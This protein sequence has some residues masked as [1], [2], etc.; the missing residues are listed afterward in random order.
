MNPDGTVNQGG[1]PV[2]IDQ[3]RFEVN[4]LLQLPFHYANVNDA[5]QMTSGGPLPD[6]AQF[7]EFQPNA[8]NQ[9]GGGLRAAWNRL[10]STTSLAITTGSVNYP[11]PI[12]SP[13]VNVTWPTI[14]GMRIATEGSVGVGAF[15]FVEQTDRFQPGV[16]NFQNPDAL[17]STDFAIMIPQPV[18]GVGSDFFTLLGRPPEIMD[19]TTYWMNLTAVTI[20]DGIVVGTYLVTSR[21]AM[22][23]S[24]EV[25]QFHNI[26]PILID[27]GI[28]GAQFRFDGTGGGTSSA[29]GWEFQLNAL[30]TAPGAALV[31]TDLANDVVFDVY[32]LN[33]AT[34]QVDFA[35]LPTV[36]GRTINDFNNL[37][38]VQFEGDDNSFERPVFN[39]QTLV[40]GS[41]STL[42]G[43]E[44]RDN[45]AVGDNRILRFEL[46]TDTNFTRAEIET[47]FAAGNNF[48]IAAEGNVGLNID[49]TGTVRGTTFLPGGSLLASRVRVE[50]LVDDV[51]A[52]I[53]AII[54]YTDTD[55]NGWGQADISGNGIYEFGIGDTRAVYERFTRDLFDTLQLQVTRVINH[56]YAW[57]D[58][59]ADVLQVTDAREFRNQ[60]Q[61]QPTPQLLS[62]STQFPTAGPSVSGEDRGNQIPT[63]RGLDNFLWNTNDRS[64]VET[65]EGAPPVNATTPTLNDFVG[66]FFLNQTT[67][68]MYYWKPT[69]QAVANNEPRS[70]GNYLRIAG[71]TSV[72]TLPDNNP[73][74]TAPGVDDGSGNVDESNIR[75]S[76][77]RSAVY[78]FVGPD[79]DGWEN[80]HNSGNIFGTPVSGDI[81]QFRD[82]GTIQ[83]VPFEDLLAG[84][85]VLVES[86]IPTDP[87]RLVANQ[88]YGFR[89]STRDRQIPAGGPRIT[90]DNFRLSLRTGSITTALDVPA[91]VFDSGNSDTITSNTT[92]LYRVSWSADDIARI[93]A[94]TPATGEVLQARLFVPN[95]VENTPDLFD[96]V[97]SHNPD[98]DTSQ[99]V[100]SGEAVVGELPVWTSVDGDVRGLRSESFQVLS[101]VNGLLLESDVPFDAA[102]L[103]AN[104]R[105]SFRVSTAFYPTNP[106]PT[107]RAQDFQISTAGLVHGA[108]ILDHEDANDEG[109]ATAGQSVFL[110]TTP[111]NT[112]AANPDFSSLVFTLNGNILNR[113]T[114]TGTYTAEVVPNPNGDGT[115]VWQITLNRFIAQDQSPYSIQFD[116]TTQDVIQ[117]F[118]S[119]VYRVSWSQAD[120]DALQASAANFPDDVLRV[121]IN[122]PNVG[123]TLVLHN[124][125]VSGSEITGSGTTGQLVRWAGPTTLEATTDIGTATATTPTDVDD[126]STRVAT[127]EFVHNAVDLLPVLAMPA[128]RNEIDV[129]L[130]T[131][132]VSFWRPHLG[133]PHTTRIRL[134]DINVSGVSPISITDVTG[135]TPTMDPDDG[136]S[137]VLGSTNA[138]YLITFRAVDIGQLA[139]SNLPTTFAVRYNNGLPGDRSIFGVVTGDSGGTS[140]LNPQIA[141]NHN[142]IVANR[143]EIE[144]NTSRIEA[145]ENQINSGAGTT[146]VASTFFSIDNVPTQGGAG[147]DDEILSYW[148][149][150]QNPN[151]DQ[152][153]PFS[154]NMPVS[155]RTSTFTAG[156][157][158]LPANIRDVL[159]TALE[160]RLRSL[161][162]YFRS[163]PGAAPDSTVLNQF[164][165][166]FV[167][168]AAITFGTGSPWITLDVNNAQ[169]AR[170]V[171]HTL[172]T[173][174]PYDMTTDE[175]TNIECRW[176]LSRAGAGGTLDYGPTASTTNSLLIPIESTEF[177]AL[178]TAIND[179]A[180]TVFLHWQDSQ[181]RRLIE[182]VTSV[183]S[184]TIVV[185]ENLSALQ[186]HQFTVSRTTASS[187]RPTFG[188]SVRFSE[189]NGGGAHVPVF[190]VGVN[191]IVTGPDQAEVDAGNE[192][193]RADGGW[194]PVL[195]P[196]EP[197]IPLGIPLTYRKT[198]LFLGA[199][200]ESGTTALSVGAGTQNVSWTY[201]TTD[202]VNYYFLDGVE[203]INNTLVSGDGLWT[204]ADPREVATT[205]ITAGNSANL[206]G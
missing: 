190:D 78:L 16:L 180:R 187:L 51:A 147:N 141:Q 45:S 102:D 186:Y 49:I 56:Q 177:S 132:A 8:D 59:A 74:T 106:T 181:G 108:T 202:E 1:A 70:A 149:L 13:P 122:L 196:P 194:H 171:S 107:L 17:A 90:A 159:N 114:T 19:E 12:G 115:N 60:L 157:T 161:D 85:F 21:F 143:G 104:F 150:G 2:L 30:A 79:G 69:D 73:P 111:T 128:H 42:G 75:I 125:T 89:I 163:N 28:P 135:Q 52:Q 156:S 3:N 58:D 43:T 55:G 77:D 182:P 193:L 18:A 72:S 184:P 199:E 169:A 120:V 95:N 170:R 25:V 38:N 94:A 165:Q 142:D 113:G 67:N 50:L 86:N 134:T 136:N 105:Y 137:F 121:F 129:N 168:G 126:D 40:N 146:S 200:G 71:D 144:H 20:A 66:W 109:M 118:T 7:I 15:Q 29:T 48:R 68:E 34:S 61:T 164:G 27:N 203:L 155:A 176:F 22:N 81:A 131:Y 119:R 206:I 101:S 39:T 33:N 6:G 189:G 183:S 112:P 96:L 97:A 197:T 148:T 124:Q 153:T 201:Y 47:D 185:P 54:G 192:F 99:I 116:T 83:G 87:Q 151:T 62:V 4:N 160:T 65:R 140:T 64:L 172:S 154:L 76:L 103:Q 174:A 167:M 158:E 179:D 11:N 14:N 57:Y 36:A 166:Q 24:E 175:Y 162:A 93:Q 138:T 5:S 130:L 145:I 23:G 82:A 44:F 41:Y 123:P 10:V 117:S 139:G 205:P 88:L 204:I 31:N 195:I 98:L 191:G 26:R 91:T 63:V 80:L 198:D 152:S 133:S 37:A 84:E 53:A 100:R 188:S 46:D 92:R 173:P 9:T 110:S 127:T 178:S 35:K 32:E